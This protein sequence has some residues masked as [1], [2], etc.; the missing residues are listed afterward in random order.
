MR[1]PKH[2]FIFIGLPFRVV[3][4]IKRENRVV[5]TSA[6]KVSNQIRS[7]GHPCNTNVLYL[8]RIGFSRINCKSV[9]PYVRNSQ[10][11]SN[12]FSVMATVL[13]CFKII[14]SSERTDSYR[15]IVD[16][17]NRFS[18]LGFKVLEIN[19]NL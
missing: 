14:S 15:L 1:S 13:N 10:Y 17:T 19:S 12:S 9:E 7:C 4:H 18:A 16:K 11:F 8:C 5:Q 2:K 3:L 6:D